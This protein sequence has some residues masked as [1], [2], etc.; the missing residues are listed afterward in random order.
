MIFID[1]GYLIAITSPLDSLHQRALS[2]AAAVQVRM[3]V[4]EYVLLETVNYFSS[5]LHRLRCH[6]LLQNIRSSSDWE[7]IP[8]SPSLFEAGLQ[9]HAARP[10]KEWSLTDCI[11]FF[12]MRERGISRALAYDHHFEQAGFAPLLRLEP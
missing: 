2:W 1:T 12:V 3:L 11:S 7:I 10:D 5:P 9:L 6:V 4:T 8:A